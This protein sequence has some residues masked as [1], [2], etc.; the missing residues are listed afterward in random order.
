[1]DEHVCSSPWTKPASP[2][3]SLPMSKRQAG[4]LDLTR[5]TGVKTWEVRGCAIRLWEA[6]AA[7]GQGACGLPAFTANKAVLSCGIAASSQIEGNEFWRRLLFHCCF[8]AGEVKFV[9]LIQSQRNLCAKETSGHPSAYLTSTASESPRL[10]FWLL[11][12]TM[13][14]LLVSFYS[15]LFCIQ[16]AVI[17][18]IGEHLC[19]SPLVRYRAAQQWQQ[20]GPIW[21]H[22]KN[23]LRRGI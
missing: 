18:L 10:H 6:L 16:D 3:S 2:P 1:M 7:W 5:G 9:S 12:S 8:P 20:C 23:I 17:H 19:C 13:C 21:C 15:A 4:G 22:Q 11:F 14:F